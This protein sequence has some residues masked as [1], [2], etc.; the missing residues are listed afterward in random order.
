MCKVIFLKWHTQGESWNLE[1]EHIVT[2]GKDVG[3]GEMTSLPM[4]EG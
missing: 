4:A 1:N 2:E 3:G